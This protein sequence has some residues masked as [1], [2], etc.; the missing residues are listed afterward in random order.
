MV[1]QQKK[2]LEGAISEMIE[3]MYRTHL[4]R[5]QVSV[6]PP[7]AYYEFL[8]RTLFPSPRCTAVPPAA[9]TMIEGRWRAYRTASRSAPVP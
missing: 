3:D 4:R 9:A 5:M 8:V 7:P 2:R 6:W 1:E